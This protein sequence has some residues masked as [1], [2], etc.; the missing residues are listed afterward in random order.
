MAS[1]SDSHHY[2]TSTHDMASRTPV[3]ELQSVS[4]TGDNIFPATSIGTPTVTVRA[5]Q[6]STYR[7]E[8]ETVYFSPGSTARA[9]STGFMRPPSGTDGLGGSL[10]RS[11]NYDDP[12]YTPTSPTNRHRFQD[13]EGR[14]S[15]FNFRAGY[16]HYMFPY[17]QTY[18]VSE[19][20]G[21]IA[22]Y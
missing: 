1:W 20:P 11:R 17:A 2:R 6:R 9:R 8:Q 12:T 4:H 16:K 19:M 13:P 7:P 21:V 22:F 3:K 5:P 18:R 14:L 15:T 10:G